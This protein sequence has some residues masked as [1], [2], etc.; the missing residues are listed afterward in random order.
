MLGLGVNRSSSQEPS[1]VARGG[2]SYLLDDYSGAAA[3]YSLRQLSSSYSGNAIKVRRSSDNAEADIRFVNGELDTT[4]LSNHCGSSNG[5]VSVWYD[6]SSSLND[7]TQTTAASQPKIYDSVT[8]VVT[9]NGKPAIKFLESGWPYLTAS[10]FGTG[11]TR[12]ISFVSKMDSEPSV[13]TRYSMPWIFMQSPINTLGDYLQIYIPDITN[14]VLLNFPTNSLDISSTEPT[15]VQNLISINKTSTTSEFWY[16]TNSQGT[17]SGT[18]NMA[19]GL[20]IG[21]FASY[22]QGIMTF[23]EMVIWNSDQSSNRTNIEDNINTFYSIY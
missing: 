7:A 2:A 21:R 10:G 15:N 1:V 23:H 17:G 13:G 14:S 5:F 18:Q 16:N 20:S 19:D 11:N 9:E 8:G 6:Q 22:G 4:G 3:A 12:F